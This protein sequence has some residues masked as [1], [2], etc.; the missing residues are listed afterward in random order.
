[1]R[2]VRA[3]V[4]LMLSTAG[5]LVVLPGGAA[6][7]SSITI[8]SPVDGSVVDGVITL[9]GTASD[10]NGVRA[11]RV[12]VDA[13]GWVFVDA[14]VAGDP[15][16]W[17]HA[18]DTTAFPNGAHTVTAQLSTVDGRTV[19]TSITLHFENA[20]V[21]DL[22]VVAF[23]GNDGLVGGV[24]VARL[25]F[26]IGNGGSTA[27]SEA[28]ALLEYR[29]RGDWLPIETLTF[30]I[31]AAE[32]IA[33]GYEWRSLVKVGS[34]PVRL[35]LDPHDKIL[36]SD[37]SNNVAGTTAAFATGA[38]E[39]VDLLWPVAPDPQPY[40]TKIV[41]VFSEGGVSQ[42][43]PAANV[44]RQSDWLQWR[45]GDTS[46]HTV[47]FDDGSYDS[48]EIEPGSMAPVRYFDEP[49]RFS[50]RCTLHPEHVGLV[51]VLER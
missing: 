7:G 47:T 21:Y 40:Q 42:F 25:F 44:V 9:T 13:G 22:A 17:S 29:Y 15:Y 36:E 49:G 34:Y 3:A 51:I 4:V 14:L 28:E 5:L 12:Q 43:V 18:L 11:V 16:T 10:D 38:V 31:G 1:M 20:V 41:Q 24:G 27:V 46:P 8:D 32:S 2:G 19:E 48:G 37:E 30:S 39:G 35:T 23:S 33:S 45:N 6:A 50:Y 26:E